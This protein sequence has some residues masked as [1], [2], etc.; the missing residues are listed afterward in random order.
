MIVDA[1][2]VVNKRMAE[3]LLDSDFEI[4]CFCRSGEEAVKRYLEY[5]PD[6]VTMDLVMPGADGLNIARKIMEMDHD[7]R[8]LMVSSLVPRLSEI[9]RQNAHS[10][11]CIHVFLILLYR[12]F[13][14]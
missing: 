11:V 2:R 4:V 3:L 7:A 9:Q 14:Q 10:K 5:R 6:L 1:S 8:F 12:C 13:S